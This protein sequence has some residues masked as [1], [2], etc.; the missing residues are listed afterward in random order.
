MAG[1]DNVT[2]SAWFSL[3]VFPTGRMEIFANT[4]Y[5]SGRA[6]ITDF[7]Y[8]A[9]NLTAALFGLDYPLHSA[10]MAGFSNLRIRQI[11][12]TAGVNYRLSNELVLNT[13]LAYDNYED[14]EP[15]LYDSTGKFVSVFAGISWIF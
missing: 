6:S 13:L 9:G 8:T 2:D 4:S 12:Q 15:W 3:Q 11:A 14:E 10:A 7:D 5:N 1:Y